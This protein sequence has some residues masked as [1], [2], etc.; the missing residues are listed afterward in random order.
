MAN[1]KKVKGVLFL[2][3]DKLEWYISSTEKVYSLPF[4]PAI[5]KNIDIVDPV[6]LHTLITSFIQENKLPP[7]AFTL[8]LNETV[9]FEKLI[10]AKQPAG[11][12]V[13]PGGI[14]A[15]PSPIPLH[16]PGAIP[17]VQP[18]QQPPAIL[19]P[20]TT[21]IVP[22]PPVPGQTEEDEATQ[23]QHFIE[24]IP[25]EEVTAT[26]VKT[27]EGTLVIGSNKAL[28]MAINEAFEKNGFSIDSAIPAT[29]FVK[30]VNIS[31]GFTLEVAH[32]FLARSDAFKNHSMVIEEKKINEPSVGTVSL[33]MPQRDGERK[34]LFAL[35]GVFAVLI[36]IMVVFLFRMN[37]ENAKVS[38]VP[39]PSAAPAVQAEPVTQVP[40][41]S[42]TATMKQ[43]LPVKISLTRKNASLS[44]R[45]QENLRLK[46]YSTIS[47]EPGATGNTSLVVFSES[48]P[49]DVQEEIVAIVMSFDGSAAVQFNQSP[50]MQILITL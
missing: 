47:E 32:Q 24:S 6:A 14:I 18:V 36:I 43:I 20:P 10:P 40:S 29:L 12:K 30:E 23:I 3:K 27:P 19:K 4:T 1:A 7:A 49:Q 5:I 9:L 22:V 26:N 34:R 17:A 16:S 50:G 13:S 25:F 44:A 41:A 37:A 21:P 8:I 11:K 38:Q 33:G 39:A 45:L 42:T 35:S 15:G 46:G 28:L 48:I 2:D 31:N